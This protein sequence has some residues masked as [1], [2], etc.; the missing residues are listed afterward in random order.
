MANVEIYK[1]HFLHVRFSVKYD[2]CER[3]QHTDIHTHTHTYA[4]A[5]GE[6]LQICL[7]HNMTTID[8]MTVLLSIVT[9]LTASKTVETKRKMIEK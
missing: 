4:H 1:R 3:L 7:K 8:K 9:V 5:I 2:L 6:I